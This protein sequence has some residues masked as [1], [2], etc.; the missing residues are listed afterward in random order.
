MPVGDRNRV[1]GSGCIRERWPSPQ[2]F[3][4]NP[5]AMMCRVASPPQIG[6]L[7]RF[8]ID[9]QRVGYG[10][11][12]CLAGVATSFLAAPVEARMVMVGMRRSSRAMVL[13]VVVTTSMT[14]LG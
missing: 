4:Q 7:F 14:Y 2:C 11:V 1:N 6:D 5:S 8:S 9:D 13:A 12:V 3:R 10:Q